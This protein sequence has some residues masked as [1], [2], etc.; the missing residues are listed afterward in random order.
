M[1]FNSLHFIFFLP[2][3]VAFYFATP[4]PKRW[5]WLLASSYYFYMCWNPRYI[6]LILCS[7]IVDYWAGLRLAECDDSRRRKRWLG[8]SLVINLGLLGTFKYFNFF[9]DS[10]EQAF[11]AFN[12][13]ADVPTFHA[14][15]PVGIS[16]YTFQTLSYSIDV[17]R[18]RI[19]PERHFGYFAV[20]VAFWPQLVAGPIERPDR[21]L[22]QL[23]EQPQFDPQRLSSGLSIM[24]WGFFQKLVIADRLA[25]YVD[26][27]YSPAIEAGPVAGGEAWLATYAF[28]FQIYCDFSGYSLIAIGA[29][30]IM[31]IDLMT[32]FR[33]PYFARSVADFWGRWHISLSTWF[34]DYVYIPLG[35]NRR[36]LWRHMRNLLITFAVSGLWHGAGWTFVIWGLLHGGFLI[37]TL[38]TANLRRRG[39]E[40]FG[41]DDN[42]AAWIWLQRLATFHAA[43]LGWVFF[44]APDIDTAGRLLHAMVT[45]PWAGLVGAGAPV[46]V[47][48]WIALAAVVFLL[49]HEGLQKDQDLTQML[50][51]MAPFQRWAWHFGLCA[52]ILWLG[53]FSS[54]EFIYFQF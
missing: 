34:R 16:F 28:A 37:A 50:G 3:A 44:R 43:L 32:N 23:H 15:L 54:Q 48:P 41:I 42:G 31:G 22:P 21:L 29:A 33:R 7:T 19:E 24:L 18:R 13:F 11:A 1:L 47:D 52:G 36:G 10:L 17:Y 35:G 20:F 39:R 27:V 5:I 53:V 6:V 2:L 12:I 46:P 38:L 51:S 4:R 45:D 14:L 49:L 25:P 26:A 9:A 40:R 8:A 30:R